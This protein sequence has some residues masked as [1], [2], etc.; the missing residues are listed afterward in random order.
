SPIIPCCSQPAASNQGLWARWGRV[1]S[2]RL[3]VIST[4]VAVFRK[5]R[6]S[7]RECADSYPAI[8]RP[9][10]RYSPLATSV[11]VTLK[12]I[13]RGARGAARTERKNLAGARPPFLDKH[14]LAPAVRLKI[15]F[16]VTL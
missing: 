1:T 8:R 15:D 9:S 6:N 5:W 4:S 13:F 3:P 10:I 16:D 2:T 11:N 14:G 7:W 12:S